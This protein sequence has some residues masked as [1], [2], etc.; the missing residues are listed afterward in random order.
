MRGSAAL[1]VALY[2]LGI[3]AAYFLPIRHGYLFVDLFFV[4]SGYVI[5]ASYAT[6]LN[7]LAELRTFVIRRFG[8]LFPLLIFSTVVFALMVNAIVLAKNFALDYGLAAH[9]HHP[10][11]TQYLLPNA[12]ELLSVVTMTHGLGV[13]D[14]LIL[15]TPSWSISTEFFTYLLFAASCLLFGAGARLWLAVVLTASSLAICIWASIT[16]HDCLR[17]QGCLSLTYDFGMV[18]CVHSFFL[19]VLAYRARDLVQHHR[20]LLQAASLCALGLL[21]I[22]LDSLPAIAFVF[23]LAFSVLILSLS[24]DD[25]WLS[26]ILRRA[27]FQNLGQRSYSIYMMHMPLLLVFDNLSKRVHNDLGS[28]L[29]LAIYVLTLYIVS[30]WTYRLVEEPF[31]VRFNRLAAGRGRSSLQKTEPVS[32]PPQVG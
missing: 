8:R 16:I 20:G 13:L 12:G 9:L 28:T 1:I 15:N 32:A 23:P 5:C 24:R 3:G 18:R 31:R 17:Q 19:G 10:D 7:N 22:S 26:D 21:L 2:H 25:G 14:R 11:A 4:L 6:R 29:V 30:G 27:P